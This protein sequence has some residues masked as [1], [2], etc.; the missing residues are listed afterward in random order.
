MMSAA[1]PPARRADD[2]FQDIKTA[3]AMYD[4]L[5]TKEGKARLV[6]YRQ[7]V[8]QWAGYLEDISEGT[9]LTEA[10][11]R[12]QAA[13]LK[14]NSVLEEA[15][16]RADAMLEDAK[17]EVAKR[18]Q[19]LEAVAGKRQKELQA[20]EKRAKALQTEVAAREGNLVSR[21]QDLAKRIAEANAAKAKADA[22]HAEW[23]RKVAALRAVVG[24]TST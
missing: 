8:E 16:R 9:K 14:A 7:L 18:Q 3:Q 4:L 24:A 10:R 6:E 17:A 21:E 13:E 5:S 23:D 2:V 15:R 20:E 12:A 1:M 19:A 22:A 11:E